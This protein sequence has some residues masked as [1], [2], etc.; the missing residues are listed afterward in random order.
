MKRERRKMS[1]E[2]EIVRERD[3]ERHTHTEGDRNYILKVR[4]ERMLDCNFVTDKLV[5]KI[6]KL[7]L[8]IIMIFSLLNSLIMNIELNSF[9]T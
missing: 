9:Y 6:N 2:R 7:S 8:F 4:R 1:T 3:R 5:N